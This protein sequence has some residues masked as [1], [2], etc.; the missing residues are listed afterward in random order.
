MH[1]TLARKVT[2]GQIHDGSVSQNELHMVYKVCA[3]FHAFI[4]KY[5]IQSFLWVC[6]STN[7]KDTDHAIASYILTELL[8]KGN[9][10]IFNLATCV[11][12]SAGWYREK[13]EWYEYHN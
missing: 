4:K 6:S 10:K 5:T 11:V 2:R 3:K 7:R 8:N 13:R 12:A 9:C 1:V